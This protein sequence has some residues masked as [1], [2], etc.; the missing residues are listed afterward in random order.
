MEDESI[1]SGRDNYRSAGGDPRDP[2]IL[3]DLDGGSAQGG[4]RAGGSGLS[5]AVGAS[6]QVSIKSRATYHVPSV[7]GGQTITLTGNY[8]DDANRRSR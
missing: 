2:D 6:A 8:F 4:L 7:I 1:D 3:S 5:Q